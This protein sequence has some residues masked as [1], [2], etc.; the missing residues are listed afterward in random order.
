MTALTKVLLIGLLSC[1]LLGAEASSANNNNKDNIDPAILAKLENLFR[2][3]GGT[4]P[5]ADSAA[6]SA[7][8]S[9]PSP[10][11]PSSS[12]RPSSSSSKSRR[13]HTS[14]QPVSSSSSRPTQTS[15]HTQSVSSSLSSSPP[16]GLS[17]AFCGYQNLDLT[18]LKNNYDYSQY[19]Y[20]TYVIYRM[21]VCNTTNEP[22]C[23][24]HGGG[25]C[26]YNS[27]NDFMA[28]L[29]RWSGVTWNYLNQSDP[30]LGV[31]ASFQ[32]GDLCTPNN[33]SSPQPIT[34]VPAFFFFLYQTPLLSF[35]L[36]FLLNLISFLFLLSSSNLTAITQVS[37]LVTGNPSKTTELAA[38][39]STSLPFSV[40]RLPPLVLVPLAVRLR[41]VPL[42]AITLQER[43]VVE[44]L[45]VLVLL[46]LPNARR[47]LFLLI[48]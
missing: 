15:S 37:R 5:P 28:V 35:F 41:T 43:E 9:S 19:N 2:M 3:I 25:V 46:F 23:A 34:T 1:A 21:N 30:A 39:F 44:P 20:Y 32:N 17:D 14:R 11:T 27:S 38:T 8:P 48:L 47:V 29:A 7:A 31:S 10:S 24:S 13:T 16:L 12:S 40:V 36:S 26:S 6:P 4:P 33:M 18:S 22:I 42:L 45:L